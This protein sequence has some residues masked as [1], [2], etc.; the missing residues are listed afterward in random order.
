MGAKVESER[1]PG[2]EPEREHGAAD[3]EL[4]VVDLAGVST[5]RSSTTVGSTPQAIGRKTR[6][7]APNS[8][9]TF[10]CCGEKWL[11]S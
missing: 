11:L 3:L 6:G 2:Y 8:G 10:M 4:A 7:R 9:S 1:L 5:L